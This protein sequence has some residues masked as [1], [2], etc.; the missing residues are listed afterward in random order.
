MFSG[1]LGGGFLTR[2][3]GAC[4]DSVVRARLGPGRPRRNGLAVW[5]E[6]RHARFRRPVGFGG[7]TGGLCLV[8]VRL[9]DVHLGSHP[10][11]GGLGFGPP[12]V[13]LGR[14]PRG[15]LPARLRRSRR[16]ASRRPGAA[17][18]R[19]PDPVG[20]GA[21]RGAVPLVTL[22]IVTGFSIGRAGGSADLLRTRQTAALPPGGDLDVPA[23]LQY[24]GDGHA[25]MQ[26]PTASCEGWPERS[27]ACFA[28]WICWNA[29]LPLLLG[30][31]AARCGLCCLRVR[32]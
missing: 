13:H 18:R 8:G 1:L 20:P 9:G 5:P 4:S 25:W 31:L 14:P 11:R 27:R 19:C 12:L 10:F 32:T 26:G 22:A 16:S 29:H 17:G 24:S 3:P 21:Q 30:D 6:R 23:P 28:G 15:Q 2:W 7:G